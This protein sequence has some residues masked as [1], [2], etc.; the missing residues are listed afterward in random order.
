MQQLPPIDI[1]SVMANAVKQPGGGAHAFV[2]QQLHSGEPQVPQY[3]PQ[4]GANMVKNLAQRAFAMTDVGGVADAFGMLGQPSAME[5]WRQGDRVGAGMT[6]LGAIPLVGA[7]G[8]AG[9]AAK[10]VAKG[11]SVADMLSDAV[12][13]GHMPETGAS[14][15]RVTSITNGVDLA[16]DRPRA[17][18]PRME[19][20]IGTTKL[21]R[22]LGDFTADYSLIHAPEHKIVSPSDLQGSSLIPTLGDRTYGDRYLTHVNGQQLDEPTHMQAGHSFMY[23]EAARG[24]DNALWASDPGIIS[25]LAGMVRGE[26]E[27]GFRPLLNYTPMSPTSAD[28]SHHMTDTLLGML[29]SSKIKRADKL[30]FN[31][32]MRTNTKNKWGAYADFPGIDSPHLRDWLYSGG[33][34]L[35]RTKLAQLMSLGSFRDRGFPA[36]DAARFATTD[37]GLLHTPTYAS[38]RTIGA[39]DPRGV[40]ID[41][42]AVPHK[43]YAAQIAGEKGG[44]YVGGFEH[45]IP[46]EVMY[47]EWI[48]EKQALDPVTYSNPSMLQYTFSRELPVARMDQ[49]RVDRLEGYLEQKRKGLIP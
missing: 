16:P 41:S 7:V 37:H 29:P 31:E 10:T 19:H 15:G 47:P 8:R 38:G 32:Q 48:A 23:G 36:T 44:G 12:K 34:A 2:Q 30:D 9:K 22:A 11:T 28:Y 42:P 1:G 40:V 27:D 3:D 25:R 33:P 24:P 20:G 35:A 18:D 21:S 43:T 46:F 39:P 45:D 26:A 49:Q 6:M 17:K 13:A 4:G 5:Q 14:S